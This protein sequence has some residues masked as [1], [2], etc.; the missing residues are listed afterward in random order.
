MKKGLDIPLS[1]LPLTDLVEEK[2]RPNLAALDLGFFS[3]RRFNF[4]KKV[5]ETV[6][7]GEA[8]AQDKVLQG[9]NYVAPASGK[10]VEIIRGDK[11]RPLKVVIKTDNEVFFEHSLCDYQN[12]TPDEIIKNMGSSG[13]LS[14]IR[15]R[16]SNTLPSC[17]KPE[18]IFIRGVESAPF[19]VD[20]SLQLRGVE[21]YFQIGLDVL[22][23]LT[24]QLHLITRKGVA[25]PVF[26]NAKNVRLH[27]VEGPHPAANASVH[28]Y[29]IYPI[30]S[31]SQCVWTLDVLG[32][33]L[34]GR[35]FKDGIYHNKKVI[36]L[37]GESIPDE[38]RKYYNVYFG[39]AVSEIIPGKIDKT[40]IISG[41]P[42]TGES[43]NEKGFLGFNHYTLCTVS[44]TIQRQ[45]FHFMGMGLNKYT[46]TKTYLSGFFKNRKS[47]KNFTTHKHGE[48]RAFVDSDVYQ[49]VM[50][51][52]IPVMDLI[53]AVLS[54]DFDK[55]VELGLLEI[56]EEDF[57]L[58]TFI[59]PSKI[60]MTQII[61]DG[62]R[63]FA[64][65]YLSD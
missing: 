57:A 10:I 28:I 46:A 37:C 45:A 19:V 59:C 5:G 44:D 42:L 63:N 30:L 60:E 20:P 18:A 48:V 22:A 27:T 56:S 54:E 58:P 9:I 26:K 62:L 41:D 51:M 11:R 61:K 39:H 23:K 32:V 38:Y 50:P 4:F 31:V 8:I 13:L 16:P 7:I 65:Q 17:Q 36:S 49:K 64:S 14:H 1:G 55:A 25:D 52:R 2:K 33:V 24:D 3:D 6:K 29:H 53:K 40:R 47:P 12:A 43:V 21:E 34:I 15:R 35:L